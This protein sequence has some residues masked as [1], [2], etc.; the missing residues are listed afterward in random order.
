MQ[1]LLSGLLFL[2]FTCIYATGW[3]QLYLNARLLTTVN[4]LSDNRITA[5]YKDAK[6]YIWIGTKNGLNKYNGQSFT[7]YKP[8][9]ENSISNEIINCITGDKEGNIWVGTMNGLN[10]LDAVTNTWTNWVPDSLGTNTNTLQNFLIWDLKWDETG[11]LWIACDV[12]EFTSYNPSTRKFEYYDW[13]GFVQTIS[14]TKTI[15][16]YHAIQSFAQKNREEFWLA[17]NK[18]LV[19]L[20]TR[21]RTFTFVGGNYYADII[22][23]QYDAESQQVWVSLEGG[24]VFRYTESSGRYEELI[25]EQEP[26]PSTYLPNKLEK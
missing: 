11:V 12:K 22:D 24:Q 5:I 10:R 20:N 15:E 23:I 19:H 8:A 13:P 4:G 26:Y 9:K 25:P 6:G 3:S 7:I 18:G 1:K 14:G 17:S 2:L 16:G 21:T